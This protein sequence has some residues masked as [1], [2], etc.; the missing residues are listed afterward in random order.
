MS[1]LL[2]QTA[3]VGH[4]EKNSNVNAEKHKD[5]EDLQ[6]RSTK[7]KKE[8]NQQFSTRSSLPKDYTEV[9]AM[10]SMENNRGS[11][12][13]RLLGRKSSV[14]AEET[15]GEEVEDGMEEEE[16]KMKKTKR[17]RKGNFDRNN[18]PAAVNTPPVR[19]NDDAN[20]LG[21]RFISL[22]EDIPELE[23]EG[24]DEEENVH[25]LEKEGEDINEES[26]QVQAAFNSKTK[27]KR[28]NGGSN[29]TKGDSMME[30]THKESKLATRGVGSFK[31][32]TGAHGKKG[33]ENIVEK[34]EAQIL[35]SLVGQTKWQPNMN[36]NANP[37]GGTHVKEKS[38]GSKLEGTLGPQAVT[39]PN[40]PKP[41]NWG[42]M[43]KEL[44]EAL[45]QTWK[46]WGKHLVSRNIRD[47][48]SNLNFVLLMMNTNSKIF[49]WNCRGVIRTNCG[50]PLN[51]LV[52]MSLVLQRSKD[53]PEV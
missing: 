26:Q 2:G 43:T 36:H 5:E 14:V 23:K 33:V 48:C 17:N 30:R 34:M 9:V 29:A 46:W 18:T 22:R 12:C 50:D 47:V 45:I 27:N 4:D 37:E 52:M 32:K 39:Q 11:Y 24:V 1:A 41:P 3:L 6:E 21:S 28:D 15:E 44:M 31:G 35:D 10:Q 25:E 51:C 38:L 53:T 20:I 42:G 13:D 7:K 8:G 16:E 19:I 49:V 40:R